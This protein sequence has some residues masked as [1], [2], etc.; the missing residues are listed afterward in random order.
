MWPFDTA[1]GAVIKHQFENRLPINYPEEQQRYTYHFSLHSLH[2]RLFSPLTI[3]AQISTGP[4]LPLWNLF[5]S[6]FSTI[7]FL[8][9]APTLLHICLGRDSPDGVATGLESL[10]VREASEAFGSGSCGVWVALFIY[11]KIPELIDTLFLI[12]RRRPII[13]LHWYHHITVLLFCFQSYRLE[14]PSGLVFCVMNY[15]VHAVMYGYYF[16]TS[17]ERRPA[18]FR[19]FYVTF[20]QLSQMFVGVR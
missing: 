20:L 5:L 3:H 6:V 19:P 7:G 18:F 11:S 9:T 13:F 2:S 10:F 1:I 12:L 16:L 17:I 15:G 14:S 8:R 4:F